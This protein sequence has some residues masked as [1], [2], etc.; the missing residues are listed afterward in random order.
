M[1]KRSF[2]PPELKPYLSVYCLCF[3]IIK[4]FSDSLATYMHYLLKGRNF[5]SLSPESHKHGQNKVGSVCTCMCSQ[6]N[7][8]CLCF[9]L[10]LGYKLSIP[11]SANNNNKK[12]HS[13]IHLLN[14]YLSSCQVP[15]TA[16][17]SGK[18]IVNTREPNPRLCKAYQKL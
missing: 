5:V 18:I 7:K 8:H 1:G 11:I 14:D 13:F 15:V 12:N 4:L 16:L 2:H 3:M 10:L 6:N 17:G 9:F